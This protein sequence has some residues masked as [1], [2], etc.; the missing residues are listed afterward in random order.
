MPHNAPKISCANINVAD[1]NSQWNKQLHLQNIHRRVSTLNASR[2]PIS[3]RSCAGSGDI[4]AWRSLKSSCTT[5][6]EL[7]TGLYVTDVSDMLHE[8]LVVCAALLSSNSGMLWPRLSWPCC[9]MKT[10][11]SKGM[12]FSFKITGHFWRIRWKCVV[13]TWIGFNHLLAIISTNRISSV[14]YNGH[15]GGSP[16][17]FYP[18]II[19]IPFM[20]PNSCEF[21]NNLPAHGA[22]MI[23][24]KGIAKKTDIFTGRHSGSF[25]IQPRS[26]FLLTHSRPLWKGCISATI[27]LR[28]KKLSGSF[29]VLWSHYVYVP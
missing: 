13:P 9:W 15:N 17:A 7:S 12:S 1:V 16:K 10:K 3:A 2:R 19:H 8:W 23:A 21:D 28:R 6:I 27:N 22:R 25:I 24:A 4:I 14:L 11:M 26:L 20:W 18:E 29:R 5:V